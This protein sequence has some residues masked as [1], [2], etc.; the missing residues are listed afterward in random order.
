MNKLWCRGFDGVY[1]EVHPISCVEVMDGTFGEFSLIILLKMYAGL[2]LLGNFMSMTA[3]N[4]GYFLTKTGEV[5]CRLLPTS[6]IKFR[7]QGGVVPIFL[8]RTGEDVSM[9]KIA[10]PNHLGCFR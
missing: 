9:M 6:W 7:T 8:I 10:L 1:H 5:Y 2:R 3:S 4:F